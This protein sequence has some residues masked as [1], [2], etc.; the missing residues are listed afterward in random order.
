MDIIIVNAYCGPTLYD[1][2]LYR[3]PYEKLLGGL[4]YDAI[5]HGYDN[6]KLDAI[7]ELHRRYM[8]ALDYEYNGAPANMV[9]DF[10][11]DE[12]RSNSNYFIESWKGPVYDKVYVKQFKGPLVNTNQSECY[13]CK[14]IEYKNYF[15][16]PDIIV[17]D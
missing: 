7:D 4:V 17:W 14:A 8:D 12:A 16:D 2:W 9:F 10:D 11:F 15:D 13:D 3:D 1:I 5:I 6:T